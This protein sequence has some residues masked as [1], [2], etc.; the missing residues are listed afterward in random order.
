MLVS[1]FGLAVAGAEVAA[2]GGAAA[3]GEAEA[4]KAAGVAE[5]DLLVLTLGT[6][7][8]TADWTTD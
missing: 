6:D 5:A 8:K 7:C 2:V 1:A 4:A 3:V